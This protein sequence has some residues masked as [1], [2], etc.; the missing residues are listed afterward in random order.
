LAILGAVGLALGVA[1]AL[2]AAVNGSWLVPPEGRLLEAAKFDVAIGIYLLTL[3]LLLPLA[4]MSVRA[5]ARWLRW[6]FALILF[7]YA[8]ENVQAW[9]GLDPRFSKVAGPIDQALGGLF[10]LSALG[11]AV[12]FVILL[13]RFFRRDA[14][15]DH[16]SLRTAVRYGGSAALLGFG[17]GIAMSAVQGRTV[18]LAGN[19][20]PIHAAGFHGLQAVPVVALLLDWAGAGTRVT[21]RWTHI[22]GIAWLAGCFGLIAQAAAGQPPL[23]PTW[24]LSVSIVGAI[25]WAAS[26]TYAWRAKTAGRSW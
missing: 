24:A 11:V 15:A 13:V 22:A 3:A 16:P 7:A 19:L 21:T 25:V 6:A 9:R 23:A 5:R 12:L 10:F 14:L 26:F 1:C 2:V 18:P 8:M 20:M 17:V 4:G